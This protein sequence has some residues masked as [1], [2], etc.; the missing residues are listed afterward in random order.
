M[1]VCIDC[2]S[3]ATTV[4]L[5]SEPE[6]I[7]S[8]ITFE[9]ADRKAHLSTHVMFKVHRLIFDRD[10]ARIESFAKDTLNSARGI[11]S[12]LKEDGEPMP[13]CVQCKTGVSFPCWCCTE[14]TGERELDKDY[15]RN[16]VNLDHH[17]RQGRSSS[18]TDV[19]TSNSL[20]V[21]RT[22]RCIR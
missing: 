6:C 7:N 16:V 4:D 5:C 2:R 12:R 10:V 21:K 15:D 19:S 9:A 18:A 13:D 20:S 17:A 1:I 14:C 3:E 22:P 8:T 11:I